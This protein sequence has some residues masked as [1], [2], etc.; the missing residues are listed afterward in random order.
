MS[1]IPS[2]DGLRAVSFLLVFGDHVGL[3]LAVPGSS[4]QNITAANTPSSR[5]PHR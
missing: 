3:G 2:L 1:R 5:S 4:G